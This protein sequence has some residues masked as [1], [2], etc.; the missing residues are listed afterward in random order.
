MIVMV[1]ERDTGIGVSVAYHPPS[2]RHI[3]AD[4]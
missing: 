4:S 2:F 1:S 3:M